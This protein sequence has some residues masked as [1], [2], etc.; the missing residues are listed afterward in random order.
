M[1]KFVVLYLVPQSAEQAMQMSPEQSKAI[2]DAWME[3]AKSC[4]DKMVDMGEPLG[5]GE[6]VTPL[7]VSKDVSNV[8]GYSIMQGETIEDVTVLFKTHPHLQMP[9]A[10]IE[11]YEC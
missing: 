8:A 7:G 11:V 10:E 9:N 2:M 3:W 5:K 1:K 6:K 4:G